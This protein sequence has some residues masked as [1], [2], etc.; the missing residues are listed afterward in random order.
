MMAE[1]KRNRSPEEQEAAFK[2]WLQNK[3]LRDTTFAYLEKLD[4][5]HAREEENLKQVAVALRAAERVLGD[6]DGGGGGD[7]YG[8]PEA[9]PKVSCCSS[10]SHR[11]VCFQ[12]ILSVWLLRL[13]RSYLCLSLT[14]FFRRALFLVMT[15]LLCIYRKRVTTLRKRP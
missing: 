11:G 3:T 14:G 9:V 13:P 7:D 15:F 4:P 12:L 8:D 6:T 1:E 10:N 5:I 2:S